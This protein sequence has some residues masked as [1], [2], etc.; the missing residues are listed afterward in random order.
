M[1]KKGLKIIR[2]F[3][4]NGDNVKEVIEDQS[5]KLST[6]LSEKIVNKDGK[7][8]WK[9]ISENA[10]LLGGSQNIVKNTY[11]NL[12]DS[13]FTEIKNLDSES[14]ANFVGSDI[15][16]LSNNRVIFG[17]GMV[18]DGSLGLNKSP[19]L[20][21]KKGY[22]FNNLIAFQTVPIQYDN[23]T[24]ML[25]TYAMRHVDTGNG[26]VLY[27]IKKAEFNVENITT[28]GNKVPN[29]PDVTYNGKMDVTTRVYLNIKINKDEL[30]RW[31]G[32]KYNSTQGA[33][34]NGIVLFAGRPAE[35]TINGVKQ[36]TFLDVIAT[37]RVNISDVLLENAEIEY[38]YELFYV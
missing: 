6:K 18:N 32:Y 33:L 14:G 37:N 21:Y 12:L 27:F 2:D 1:I 11:Y 10:L 3:I 8:L 13:Q 4:T 5:V 23:P 15:K 26:Y 20:K 7:V 25:K 17:Y 30:V 34:M 35:V 31:F 16:Y 9:P 29:N 38:L 36:T 24:E 19:V 28:D 22:N